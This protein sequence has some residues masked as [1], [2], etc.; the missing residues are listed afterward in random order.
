MTLI[1][2]KF[3]NGL[4]LSLCGD[5]PFWFRGL[6][7]RVIA[8]YGPKDSGKSK[9]LEGLKDRY[10]RNRIVFNSPSGTCITDGGYGE[11][12]T[13]MKPGITKKV[14]VWPDGDSDWHI[15][16]GFNA[17]DSLIASGA[18]V[19]VFVIASECKARRTCVR[20]NCSSRGFVPEFHRKTRFEEK[21]SYKLPMLEPLFDSIND[22]DLETL[23]DVIFL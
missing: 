5:S 20:N 1:F 17:L 14:A 16:E 8:L 12:S 21:S 22:R 7:M 19:D 2:R 11:L 23:I 10:L 9:V 15:D 18:N 4:S 13:L 6:E 3:I